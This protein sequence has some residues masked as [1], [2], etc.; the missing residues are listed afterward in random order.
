MHL[1]A[2]AKLLTG[3]WGQCT[4][5]GELGGRYVAPVVTASL[6]VGGDAMD[7]AAAPCSA[8]DEIGDS[9]R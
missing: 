3:N 2:T 5:V 6:K 7:G 9:T 1:E 8:S 4:V